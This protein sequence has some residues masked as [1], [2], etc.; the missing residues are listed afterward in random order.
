LNGRIIYNLYE[1]ASLHRRIGH[2]LFHA[3]GRSRVSQLRFRGSRNCRSVAVIRGIARKETDKLGDFWMDTTRCLLWVLLP[4]CLVGSLVFV[5][6]G[7]IQNLRPYTT[8]E[9]GEPQTVQVTGADGKT[10]A[11]TVMQQIIARPSGVPRSD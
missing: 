5:S 7:V 11:Q 3:D 6:Q 8:V 10:T 9:L 2:E 4:I 1:L